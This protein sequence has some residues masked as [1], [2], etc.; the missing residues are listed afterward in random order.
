MVDGAGPALHLPAAQL[1]L[2]QVLAGMPDHG[3][4]ATNMAEVDLVMTEKVAGGEP[5][6]A[7]TRDR[8]EAQATTGTVA[9][10][11]ARYW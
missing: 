1:L 6:G 9:R 10:L 4:P 11:S 7:E 5:R 8:A 2:A 3:R